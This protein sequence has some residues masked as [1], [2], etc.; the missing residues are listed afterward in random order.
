MDIRKINKLGRLAYTQSLTQIIAP[1]VLNKIKVLGF[2]VEYTQEDKLISVQ[3][4]DNEKGILISVDNLNPMYLYDLINQKYNLDNY[5]QVYLVSFYS[6]A[7]LHIIEKF[8]EYGQVIPITANVYNYSMKVS[9]RK[10]LMIF[11]IAT[12]F[13]DM[14]KHSLKAIAP[15]FGLQKLEYNVKNLSKENLKDKLF[16]DYAINDA[17]LCYHIFYELRKYF[18]ENFNVDIAITL[19]PA[20]TALSI[21]RCKF[22]DIECNNSNTNSRTLSLLSAWGGRSEAYYRGT[23]KDDFIQVDMKSCYPN[24]VINLNKLPRNN[25]DYELYYNL[26]EFLECVGG[27]AKVEFEFPKDELYPCLPSYQDKLYYVLKGKSYC[28]LE[29]IK[30]AIELGANIKILEAIGYNEGTTALKDFME[31]FFR[32]KEYAEKNN[33][34]SRRA[35]TKLM[36]NS[37]V[38]KFMQH[39][40]GFDLE[41]FKQL[42]KKLDIPL[43][44]C[45]TLTM[46]PKIREELGINT[47]FRIGSGWLPE[48]NNLILGYA[49][50]MISRL[51]RNTNAY[52]SSTDSVICKRKD[53]NNV[54]NKIKI[55][56]QIEGQSNELK[57]LRTRVY[58]LKNVKVAHHAI[59]LPYWLAEQLIYSDYEKYKTKKQITL[60]QSI[61]NN[62]L[63]ASNYEKVLSFCRD[64]DNKRQLLEDGNS[65]PFKSLEYIK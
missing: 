2:D 48:W 20:H 27:F 28:S 11:D 35:M 59:H 41:T 12:W 47:Q 64:W 1:R 38:G 30:F 46:S 40:K 17:K 57:I 39:K 23:F 15:M 24:S 44:D 3:L 13:K 45:L 43:T 36:M 33:D 49:R 4:A 42:S 25:K 31:Y 56:L 63:Y 7:E 61:I 18:L 9:K 53:Y 14:P 26:D 32:Q 6:P 8:W 5:N 19:T 22:L 58:V 65:I 29:E 16:I 55:P 51:I 60:R 34:S 62:S 54:D 37:L 52:L 50:A 21:F 10:R